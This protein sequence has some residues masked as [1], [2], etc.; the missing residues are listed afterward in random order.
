[1]W[2][3]LRERDLGRVTNRVALVAFGTS[4]PLRYL[5]VFLHFFLALLVQLFLFALYLVAVREWEVVVPF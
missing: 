3:A 1:M 4:L 2:V 5:Y